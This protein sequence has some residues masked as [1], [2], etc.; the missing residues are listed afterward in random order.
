[1]RIREFRVLDEFDQMQMIESKGV[2]IGQLS[3][4]IYAMALFQIEGFYVEL[5][6]DTMKL[7]YKRMRIFED[8]RF[9]DPYLERI[10]ITE[11]CDCRH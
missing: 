1:M 8:P 11:L 2:L 3:S 4:G 5:T 10:D 6:F 9:L 7:T